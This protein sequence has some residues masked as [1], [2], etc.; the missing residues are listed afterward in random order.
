MVK[1]LKIQLRVLLFFVLLFIV[2]CG[3]GGNGGGNGSP[4]TSNGNGDGNQN[5]MDLY[6]TNDPDDTDTPDDSGGNGNGNGNTNNPNNIQLTEGGSAD[7][8]RVNVNG[9]TNIV[10]VLNNEPNSPLWSQKFKLNE[11]HYLGPPT[12]D[13]FN[14][15][16]SREAFVR[17]G[18]I[19]LA[20]NI[21]QITNSKRGDILLTEYV[22][23]DSNVYFLEVL[24]NTGETIIHPDGTRLGHYNN[25]DIEVGGPE[26]TGMPSGILRYNGEIFISPRKRGTFSD[27]LDY[28]TIEANFDNFTGNIQT[29]HN[30]LTGNFLINSSSGTYFGDELRMTFIFPDFE[31]NIQN[32]LAT[33]YGAFHNEGATGVSG[34]FFDNAEQRFGGA[35][36]GASTTSRNGQ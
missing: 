3:G 23:N 24:Q 28:F 29:T 20:A 30:V 32:E 31:I 22:D 27:E 1:L 5:V 34:I 4:T 11:S 13:Q 6:D 16:T 9:R 12:P 25:T 15:N 2:S 36:I 33:I 8:F 17:D 21:G 18:N 10:H 35:I 19:V 26:L 14:Y 7:G